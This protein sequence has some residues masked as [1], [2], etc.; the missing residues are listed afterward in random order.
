MHAIRRK[1][2]P[3]LTDNMRFDGKKENFML[4]F[5]RNLPLTALILLATPLLTGSRANAQSADL[6][7]QTSTETPAQDLP[8]QDP[9]QQ[10]PPGQAPPGQ[11]PPGQNPPETPDSKPKPKPRRPVFLGFD[12]G[13][14]IPT[15]S[16]TRDKFGSTW[17]DIGPSFGRITGPKLRGALTPD[18]HILSQSHD[19]NRL[20]VGLLGLEYRRPL[21]FGR[22]HR[23]SGPAVPPGEDGKPGEPPSGDK[24]NPVASDP[25]KPYFGFSADLSVGDIRDVQDGIHSGVRTGAAGSVFLGLKIRDRAFIEARYRQTSV[26]KSFDL[27]GFQLSAGY[28]FR[29]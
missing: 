5:N 9:P 15:S 26:V 4:D 19:G 12:T 20:F 18:I 11:N 21:S 7:A 6:P 14:F 13:V 17:L 29:F 27:S 10:S 28:R 24:A 3:W 23:P 22:S 8:K 1:R 25:T 16:R 2:I